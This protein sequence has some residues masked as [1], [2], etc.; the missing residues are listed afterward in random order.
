MHPMTTRAALGK[1]W[2][3]APLIAGATAILLLIIGVLIVYSGEKSYRQEKASEVDVEARILASTVVAALTFDD[4]SAAQTYVGALHVN[5]EIEAAAVYDSTGRPFAIYRRAPTLSV[6]AP[7]PDLGSSDANDRI[8][9]T[10]AVTQGASSLGRVYVRAVLEPLTRRYERYAVIALLVV[11]A[12]LVTAV[13]GASQSALSRSY[14]ELSAANVE[15]EAQ[16][17]ER[18]KAEEALRQAQKMEAIGQLTGGV[19]HDFNNI[20]QV[21]LGNLGNVERQLQRSRETDTRL[22]RGIR[23]AIR[24]SERAAVLTG[25]LLAFSRRQPLAP[26][27]VDVNKL[28]GGMSDLLHRTL[29]EAIEVET[30]LGGRLWQTLADANQLESA[31]LNLAVNA[32]DAMPSGGK[33]TVETANAY[34]DEAYAAS[35][36]DVRA[37]QFV[38]VAVSDTGTGMTPEVIRKAFDPFF[39]TKDIG[40][41]TGLGLSQVYGF[42]KQSGGHAKIYSEIGDGTTIKLYLPRLLGVGA[43]AEEEP[44]GERSRLRGGTEIILV[45]EDESDV[46]NFVVDMLRELGYQVIEA[47]DGAAAFAAIEARPDIN[48]LFTDVGLPGSFN[49]RQLADQV[50]QL[51]PGLKILYTTG[52]ARNAIVHQGRLDPGVE[53]INKPFT[54]AAL[55]AR[56]RAILDS[57]GAAG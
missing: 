16:I 9:V 42:I 10:A 27:P 4:S 49:G 33:L 28:I 41:G 8:S 34:L 29:G 15:L 46:R 48:L 12:G 37:G 52:Y 5:P 14:G 11:M 18:E 51:R 24:A 2:K 1:F 53:L 36:E 31:I 26:R 56:I 3:A 35:E 25:Q 43:A 38:I 32:R 23:A 44:S 19:A 45:V 22:V 13:L 20:L 50:M 55:A 39:T 17:A 54:Y 30:V 47:A 21:V 7:A 57:E 6:P 40:Q